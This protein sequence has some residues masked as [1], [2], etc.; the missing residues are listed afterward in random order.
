MTLLPALKGSGAQC[1]YIASAG[2][3]TA[4]ALAKKYEFTHSTTDYRQLLKDAE[5][6]LILITTRHNLHASMTIESLEAGKHVFVEK[7]LVISQQQLNKLIDVYNVCFQL[8]N[9]TITVGF[10]RRFS[11]FIQK[12]KQ[13]ISDSN[14]PINLVAT[15]NAGF[16]PPDVWVNDM[17]VGGGRIIGEACH[18]I[19]LMSFL[20][21]SKVVAVGMT[22][23]G[24][25][26]L[27]NTDNAIINL[28]FENGSQGV[29]NYFS[30][31]SKSY[32]KERF[33][34]YSQGRTLII[35]NFRKME[36][37]GFKG[38]SSMRGKLDKGHKAQFAALI[39]SLKAGN[40]PLIPFEELVNTTQASLSA[41]DSLKH[42][43]LISLS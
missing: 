39:Q 7:P 19:D 13:L 16:I 2:G 31:G 41:L 32:S 10:N 15:I 3:L 1:K 23:L 20:N 42:K 33:E 29:I 26:A 21:G 37:F 17:N 30:N 11:P 38:F 34:I 18:F 43:K 27:E 40:N 22:A 25:I 8:Y 4:N 35:D 14:T 12:A 28:K 6:D 24:K 36:G 5:V 9:K